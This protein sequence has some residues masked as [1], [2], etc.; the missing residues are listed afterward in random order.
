MLFNSVP[1]LLFLPFVV[2]VYHRLTLRQQQVFILLASYAFYWVWSFKYSAL[3]LITTVVDYSVALWLDRESDA[4][5]RRWILGISMGANLTLL[6]VFKYADFLSS[7]FAE[8]A[9]FRPWPALNLTLPL[10][11]SFYTFMSMAY[12]IDVY[13]REIPAR[14]SLLQMALF[15]SYFPHLVAGPILRASSLLPQLEVRHTLDWKNVRRGVALIL[16]GMLIK[17]Y[18]A[19]SA[20]RLVSEAYAAPGATS[21]SGL[22]LA[23]YAFAV[24]I[25]CDFSGYSDIA[26]GS[27]LLLGVRLPEN[28]QRPYLALTMRDFWR[29]WHISLSTW[30]RDYLY[31]PLGGNRKGEVRTYVN[32]FL[33]MLLGGLWHGAGWNWVIWGALHGSV[34]AVERALGIE[35]MSSANRMLRLLRWFVTFHLVCLS[36]VFFRSPSFAGAWEV[37]TRIAT[38]A[39]GEWYGGVRPLVLLG[40]VLALD[41]SGARDKWIAFAETRGKLVRWV[42]VP[43]VALLAITFQGAS[44][45][46]FIYFQF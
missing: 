35:S 12:V 8:L 1:Y 14:R 43:A 39:S 38:Q 7:S 37:V 27:A 5:K 19:D 31:V 21:G 32:L 40:L 28:F 41:F 26:I 24:Q 10:G 9:G 6:G 42:A 36:W 3:L 18:I 17:V 45:P 29:R 34:L 20:A 23:T 22:L 25:Y 16:W 33:T 13:R 2:V 15:V 11:I 46:E 30:L 4:R 44:N